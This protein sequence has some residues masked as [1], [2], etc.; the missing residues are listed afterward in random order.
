MLALHHFAVDAVQPSGIIL[1]FVDLAFIDNSPDKGAGYGIAVDADLR[2]DGHAV[3]ELPSQLRQ[4][5]CIP[6]RLIAEAVIKPAHGVLCVE[7]VHQDVLD[8]IKRALRADGIV[9]H[10]RKQVFDPQFLQ[11]L[12]LLFEGHDVLDDGLAG[13]L[14]HR[15]VRKRKNGGLQPF[16]LCHSHAFPDQHLVTLMNAVEIA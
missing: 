9:E 14:V 6:F 1:I 7:A 13:N 16:F 5:V 8:E 2:D 15:M 11:L 10:G 4:P 3:A 12:R